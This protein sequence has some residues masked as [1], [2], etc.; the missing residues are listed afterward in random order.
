[1]PTFDV[2]FEVFC[3][4]GNALCSNTTTRNSRSRNIPQAVVE[5]CDRC[6]AK[7]KDEGD[8][9]GYNRGLADGR[10]EGSDE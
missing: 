8:D 6:L 4:C 3:A 7:A 2:E 9:E 1:M 5:P 10:R